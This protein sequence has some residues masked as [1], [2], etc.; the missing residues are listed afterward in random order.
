MLV[1]EPHYE[2][3]AQQGIDPEG[4]YIAWLWFGSPASRYQLR[5]TRR[6]LRVDG[7]K[8]DNLDT[9]L[10]VVGGMK[11]RQSVRVDLEGL[12]G[13]VQVRTL[14]LDLEF[15]PTEVMALNDGVWTRSRP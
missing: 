10:E 9:L 15:W 1:H 14:K 11:D 3:A 2:V 4:I 13:S 8:I 7:Q 5:P 6:I 12:D